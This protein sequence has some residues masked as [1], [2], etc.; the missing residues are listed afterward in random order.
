MDTATMLTRIEFV[1][2]LAENRDA[3]FTWDSLALRDIQN[4]TTPDAIVDYFDT[5]L[6]Q[7]T[8][9]QA[10]KVLILEFLNTDDQ[11]QLRPLDPTN[12]A[13]FQQRVETCVGFM[14][15]LPQWHF[16]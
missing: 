11:G 14:L 3:D 10:D 9:T 6:F 13:D 2:E 4:L 12:T 1:R 16:Q 15:S 7:K 8:L 5:L